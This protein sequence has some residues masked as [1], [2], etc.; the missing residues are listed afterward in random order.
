ML[1]TIL[2]NVNVLF[3]T[4]QHSKPSNDASTPLLGGARKNYLANNGS[5]VFTHS[6][7]VQ[8]QSA[9]TTRAESGY[10]ILADI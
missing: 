9:E 2:N 10:H 7:T 3:K 5:C 1:K 8:K 6:K 4:N